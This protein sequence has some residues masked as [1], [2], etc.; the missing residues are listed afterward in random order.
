MKVFIS[1]DIEG[2]V[3]TTSWEET[4]AGKP[5]YPAACQQMTAEVKA[6]CEGAIAAGADYILVKDAHGSSRNI[7]IT[8][9]PAC[10]E[11]IRGGAGLPFSMAYGV[12]ESFDAAFFVGY[13]SPAGFNE[14]PLSHTYSTKTTCIKLNGKPCSE[15]MLYS[16]A[17][18]SVGVPTVL[19]AGDKALCEESTWLHPSLKTVAVKDGLGGCTRS[20]TPEVACQRIKEAAEAALKQDLSAAKCQTLPE[21]FDLEI[22][23][24]EHP[25]AVKMSFFPG[26]ELIGDR[27]VRLQ[28]NDFMHV[29][30]AVL[31]IF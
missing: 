21:S 16:W 4:G 1:A 24:K 20:M 8:Q 13:H 22:T 31:F 3:G 10:V 25:V 17:A 5:G 6:A 18:A 19:L 15:F 7:D 12:D 23:Y 2:I 27:T 26:C 11:L 14:N 29:L 30:R 28:T 9:L